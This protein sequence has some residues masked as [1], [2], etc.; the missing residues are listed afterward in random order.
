M[1]TTTEIPNAKPVPFPT[2]I[3]ALGIIAT[4][5]GLAASALSIRWGAGTPGTDALGYSWVYVNAALA[6]TANFRGVAAAA[7]PPDP[8]PLRNFKPIRLVVQFTP[9]TPAMLLPTAQIVP[10]TCVPWYWSSIG[11]HDDPPLTLPV[12]AAKAIALKP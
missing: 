8:L 7:V 1:T 9:T 5:L 6:W 4:G 10:E 2:A 12:V 11:I 3:A